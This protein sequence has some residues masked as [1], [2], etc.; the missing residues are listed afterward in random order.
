MLATPFF[1]KDVTVSVSVAWHC[2]AV[3]AVIVVG[4]T[5][6]AAQGPAVVDTSKRGPQVGA[7]V[8]AFSGVDQF[9]KEQSL[10]SLSGPKGLMLV[11]TR[12]AD[13]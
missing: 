5:S 4:V 1:R 9:G 6:L 10:E 8:P 13:W 7:V 3:A 12:S 11:F 2:S